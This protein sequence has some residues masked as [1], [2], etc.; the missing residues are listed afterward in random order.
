MRLLFV[1][2]A[3][4]SLQACTHAAL[5][6]VTSDANAITPTK[7]TDEVLAFASYEPA[8]SKEVARIKRMP[9]DREQQAAFVRK[10]IIEHFP[11]DPTMLRIANCES[12]GFI[13]WLKDG[14]TLRPTSI[15]KPNGRPASSAGGVFQVLL[16]LHAPDIRRLGLNMQDI[17]DYMEFV[18]Y[19]RKTQGHNAWKPS[20]YC[21]G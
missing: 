8:A 3:I 2:I 6:E 11:K 20:R 10:K 13:H 19:L 18:K 4:I 1:I 5:P 17:D 12:T 21:W 16:K 15:R 7:N 14:K 9:F